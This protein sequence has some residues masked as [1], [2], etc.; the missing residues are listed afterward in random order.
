MEDPR[1]VTEDRRRQSTGVWGL[2]WAHYKWKGS[3]GRSV[4]H[5]HNRGLW[6]A[7]ARKS[8]VQGQPGKHSKTILKGEGRCW[9]DAEEMAWCLPYKHE[10]L[11]SPTYK[12]WSGDMILK[13][14][15]VGQGFLS[16][17][18]Q[19]A[20]N[21]GQTLSPKDKVALEKWHQGLS[22]SLNT[23]MYTHTH[24]HTEWVAHA[25]K[26]SYLERR[27]LKGTT[28]KCKPL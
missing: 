6:E 25:C 7:K 18:S 21:Q 23:C 4:T 9:G 11:S 19:W 26:P 27:G 8:K 24:T 10:D 5:V 15:N 12:A 17:A 16:L 13:S 3:L 2:P 14:Q 28:S 20:P 1:A 22:S